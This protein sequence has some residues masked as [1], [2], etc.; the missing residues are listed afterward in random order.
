M[1][2]YDKI[3]TETKGIIFIGKLE[4]YP[5]LH[6][7]IA[8]LF[9]LQTERKEFKSN[10]NSLLQINF[11]EQQFFL[12]L[13]PQQ[14]FI[15]PLKNFSL[16]DTF[17]YTILATQKDFKRISNTLKHDNYDHLLLD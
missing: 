12:Y 3:T 16:N 10:E 5:D 11:F 4:N 8:H 7:Q 9:N 15:Q 1:N 2:L 13:C 6:L 14:D 17:R